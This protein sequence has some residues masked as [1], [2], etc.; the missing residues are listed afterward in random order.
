[1]DILSFAKSTHREI[2]RL[3]KY[4]DEVDMMVV[5]IVVDH[6]LTNLFI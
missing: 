1:L 2:T 5:K 4:G 3:E 6:S